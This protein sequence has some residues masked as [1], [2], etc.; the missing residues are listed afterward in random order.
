MYNKII[1]QQGFSGKLWNNLKNKLS[2]LSKIGF[3]GSDEIEEI[4]KKSKNDE[5]SIDKAT[6]EIEKFKKNQNLGQ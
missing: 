1:E 6:K 2:F 3:K 4:I 5:I